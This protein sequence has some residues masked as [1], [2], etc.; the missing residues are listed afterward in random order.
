VSPRKLILLSEEIVKWT[1]KEKLF[2][3]V[4]GRAVSQEQYELCIVW[5]SCSL[6]Q[7]RP[8]KICTSLCNSNGLFQNVDWEFLDAPLDGVV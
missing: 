6:A 5:Q 8:I 3:A 4:L 7:P 2:H 1:A